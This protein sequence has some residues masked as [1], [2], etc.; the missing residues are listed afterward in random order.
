MAITATPY[1]VFL[2]DL[3]AG[4]HNVTTDTDKVALLTS[5][6]TPDLTN[7]ASY[8]DV[9]A[10]ELVGTGY[11]AGGNTLT[12]KSVSLT[13]GIAVL[14]AAPTGWAAVTGT[15][16]YA[17]IYKSTGTNATSKLIGLI[18]FGA[19]RTYSAEALQLSFPGGAITVGPGS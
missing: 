17:V 13:A 10:R 15:F 8:A 9:I 1:G 16:R 14:A 19:D 4:V 3:F 6:Y 5:A 11:T 18:D 12:G 2:T 7:N